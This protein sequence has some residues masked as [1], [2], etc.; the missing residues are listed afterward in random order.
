MR[1]SRGFVHIGSWLPLISAWHIDMRMLQ[2]ELTLIS[3][4]LRSALKDGLKGE[5]QRGLLALE[6][7]S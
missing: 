5:M 2:T 1:L 3:L 6:I 4:I 7:N